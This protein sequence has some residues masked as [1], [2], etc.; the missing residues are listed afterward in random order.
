M[1]R[2]ASPTDDGGEIQRFV[3]QVNQLRVI[4]TTDRSWLALPDILIA[5]DSEWVVQLSLRNIFHIAPDVS[6]PA[7]KPVRSLTIYCICCYP[8]MIARRRHRLFGRSCILYFLYDSY[9]K[10]FTVVSCSK[11]R[12]A[13]TLCDSI[14]TVSRFRVTLLFTGCECRT[15]TVYRHAP[16]ICP[17]IS[18]PSAHLDRLRASRR[19]RVGLTRMLRGY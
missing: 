19:G 11:T 9:L 5:D 1:L 4:P 3:K 7:L 10:Y 12:S 2:S 15:L 17:P 18:L 16:S 8:L 14:C 6:I 13:P